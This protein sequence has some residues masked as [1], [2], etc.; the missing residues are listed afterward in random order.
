MFYE[1]MIYSMLMQGC[2]RVTRGEK[3]ANGN[4]LLNIGILADARALENKAL[5]HYTNWFKESIR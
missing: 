2:G 3:D 1:Y 5:F 4:W